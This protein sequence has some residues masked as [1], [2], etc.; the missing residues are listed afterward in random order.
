MVSD[1]SK[2]CESNSSRNF[3]RDRA[4]CESIDDAGSCANF[5]KKVGEGQLRVVIFLRYC[6]EASFLT[7]GFSANNGLCNRR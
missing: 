6:L 2:Y 1:V 5:E 4:L 7:N 3:S